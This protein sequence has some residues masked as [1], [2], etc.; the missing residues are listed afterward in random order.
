VVK[1][2]SIYVR[3]SVPENEISKIK[4]GMVATFTV[5]AIGDTP[6]TGVVSVVGVV[7]DALSR[8]YEVK[9]LADNPAHIIKPGMICDLRL[10]SPQEMVSV[11]DYCAVTEDEMGTYV[12][13]I[14]DN[15]TRVERQAV[16]TGHVTTDGI[17][18][19]SGL[20]IGD[21]VACEGLNKLKDNSKITL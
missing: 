10:N 20:Q 15:R 5:P 1:I 8:T 13:K 6:F 11:V 19:V 2:D 21:E 14:T 3:V 7:A 9:V 16:K 18:I 4:S 17:E 12:Y